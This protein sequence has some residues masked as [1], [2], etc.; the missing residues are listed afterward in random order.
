MISFT[1]AQIAAW[2]TPFLWP[3]LRVLAMFTAAPVLSLRA[4][5]VRVKLGLAFMVVLSAQASLPEMAPIALD[6]RGALGAVV[7]NVAV[8]LTIGFAARVVFAAVEFAGELVGLQM[9]LNFA[10]FFDPATGGQTT[11]VSRFFGVTVSWVFIV[12]GGHLLVIA[13]V[14]QSL[15]SFPVGPEPFAFLKA[16]EPQRWGAEI[17]AVGLW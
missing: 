16:A 12:T 6:G 2:V 8:G 9:G 1:D 15:H 14:V 13:G 17:F 11:A 4:V 10:G 3:F 5:P 7:H